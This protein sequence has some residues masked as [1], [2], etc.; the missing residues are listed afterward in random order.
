MASPPFDRACAYVCTVCSGEGCFHCCTT[1]YTNDDNTKQ[2]DEDDDADNVHRSINDVWEDAYCYSSTTLFT[3]AGAVAIA[4]AAN[5]RNHH[6]TKT[7]TKEERDTGGKKSNLQEVIMRTWSHL[8]PDTTVPIQPNGLPPP[9]RLPSS[10]LV[11][12]HSLDSLSPISFSS[13][14]PSTLSLYSP[15]LS[16]L[17]AKTPLYPLTEEE[18]ILNMLTQRSNA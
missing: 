7:E 12:L 18:S 3:S 9:S 5:E 10:P 8:F 6:E 17:R 4:A 14:P 1:I 13:P 16:P 15:P 11:P 2:F